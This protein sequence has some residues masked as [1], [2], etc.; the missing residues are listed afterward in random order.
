MN[1]MLQVANRSM[2]RQK[3]SVVEHKGLGWFQPAAFSALLLG[4]TGSKCSKG[5]SSQ[6][7]D[8]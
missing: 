5:A 2:E 4:V 8:I 6:P 1:P 7:S 3:D